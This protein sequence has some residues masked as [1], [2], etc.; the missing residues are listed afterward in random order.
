MPDYHR[1]L[2]FGVS[3]V[4]VAADARKLVELAK[5]ADRAGLDVIGIQ[6]HPYAGRFIDTFALIG[7]ILAVTSRITVFPDVANLP[8]RPA[9]MLA[10][11]ALALDQL[12]G[13]RFELGL[14]AGAQYEKIA[15]LGGPRLTPREAVDSLEAAIPVIRE[16]APGVQIWLGAYKPR[17]LRITGRHA[18]GWIPSHGYMKPDAV[19]EAAATIDEAARA[20]GRDPAELRRLYNLSDTDPHTLADYATE[21]GFDTFVFWPEGDDEATEIE[22]FATDVVPAVREEVRRRRAQA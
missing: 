5:L 4:P 19:P 9:P 3:V 6:D 8:L 13:G 17:M 18:D 15:A 10:R 7:W 14:G 1:D 16:T 21:L 12:S 20:A 22:R 2:Q 11:H